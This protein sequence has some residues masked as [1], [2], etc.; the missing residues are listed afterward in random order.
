MSGGRGRLDLD[1][2]HVLL[3]GVTGFLGQAI[4]ERLLSDSE[5]TTISV[6]IRRRGSMSAADRLSRLLRKRVFER[7]RERVGEAAAK[8][9][10]ANRIEVIEGEIG[11]LTPRA[12]EAE[13]VIH[14]AS[15]V[16]FDAPIDVAFDSNVG[17]AERLYSAL[18]DADAHPHVLHVSTAYVGGAQRGLV[19]EEPVAHQVDWAVEKT[20][21]AI[22]RERV[23]FASR[24][25]QALEGFL[26]MGRSEVGKVGPRAVAEFAEGAR[27]EWVREQLM[28]RGRDRARSLGWTDVYTLTKALSERAAEELWAPEQLTIVRPSIIESALR[29]PFPGWID[30]FKV[31]DPLILAY[32]R[33]QLR[34]FPGLPDSILDVIPVDFVVNAI[35]A[36]AAHPPAAG[37][38][39]YLHVASGSSNPMP[40][41]QMYENTREYFTQHPVPS[42]DGPIPVP[43]WTFPGPIRFEEGLVKNERRVRTTERLASLLSSRPKAR[44]W[45]E[46]T[47]QHSVDLEVLRQHADL[48]RVYVQA[49]AVFDDA[50]LSALNERLTDEARASHGFDARGIDWD[51]YLQNI[52]LPAI[53][54]LARAFD[55]RVASDRDPV[56][57]VAGGEEVLAV[58]DLEGTV[59]RG[60]LIE[61][62]LWLRRADRAALLWPREALRVVGR[63]GRLLAAERRDRSEFIRTFLRLYEGVRAED[64]RRHVGNGLGRTIRRH[65]LGEALER[66]QEHRNAGHRTVLIT[67]SVDLF[68][69][70]IASYFDDVVATRIGEQEGTLTGFLALPPIVGEARAAWLRH[71]ARSHGFDLSKAYAY[72][73]SFADLSWLSLVGHPVAVNPDSALYRHARTLRWPIEEWKRRGP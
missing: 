7:W 12:A 44:Q 25:P 47:R 58:F 72:G 68:T 21:A 73:D 65:L 29:H 19:S 46:R 53:T 9:A 24:G 30:G 28:A 2:T 10:F 54:T 13:I 8:E 48:Y 23:E 45:L 27:T 57:R 64:V 33:G 60:N 50:Q 37:E 16:Q 5:T 42:V 55:R 31:A 66:V 15:S 22:A 49:E 63:S 36:A 3:T 71:Y 69:D 18:R 4:L 67:G 43:R 59:L 14:S 39:R 17:G 1:G 51:D 62:Y 6:V 11:T 34:E 41:H 40:F 56:V 26:A 52:H 20:A 70:A 38:A 61:Q 32:G 35:L